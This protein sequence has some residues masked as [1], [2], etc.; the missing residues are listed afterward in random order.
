VASIWLAASAAFAPTFAFG[1]DLYTIRHKCIVTSVHILTAIL[2]FSN[3]KRT[4]GQIIQGAIDS[5]WK[6]SPN[7][8]D[9]NSS[10]FATAAIGLL[11]FTILP[12][13]SPYPLATVPTILGKRLSRPASAFTFLGSIICY[14]LKDGDCGSDFFERGYEHDN[15]DSVIMKKQVK[16]EKMMIKMLRYGLGIGSGFHLTLII[17]KLIGVDGG[18]LLFAGRGLWEV[19]PAMLAVPFATGM[20]MVV[21]AIICLA[22]L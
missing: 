8:D 16:S 22:A 9:P 13:I 15:I 6:A 14:R 12:I 10:L 11:W 5:I 18:G 7:F 21:H 20:S 3:V 4:P 17:L 1:Y 2:A 19:Y